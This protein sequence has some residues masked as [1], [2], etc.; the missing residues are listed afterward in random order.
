MSA[1]LEANLSSQKTTWQQFFD[2]HAAIYDDNVFTRNTMAEVDFLVSELSLRPG[3]AVLD[4]GC[5]TGRHAVELARRG[6]AVTGVD[7][8]EGM[9]AEAARAAESAGVDVEWVRADACRFSLPDRYDAAICLCEGALG[10]L[11]QADDP[12]DQP[13]GVLCGMSRHLKDGC[14]LLLT[15]LNAAA[16]FRKYAQSD[17]TDGRFDPMTVTESFEMPPRPGLP[18]V[19]VRQRAFTGSELNLLCRLAGLTVCEQWGGT[20][21]RWAKGPLDLDEIE[22]MLLARKTSEPHA[23]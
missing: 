10:L 11:S 1:R 4:V 8:S 15:T 16:L 7:L 18:P 14:R 12:I 19:A 5:G 13:L 23:F 22:I 21:G 9:L 3:Q 2:A 20:A 17:V 6:Y